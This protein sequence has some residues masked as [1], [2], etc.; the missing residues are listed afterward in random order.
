MDEKAWGLRMV[1]CINDALVPGTGRSVVAILQLLGSDV[2]FPESQTRCSQAMVNPGYLDWAV[3]VERTTPA[4]DRR[5]S[6]S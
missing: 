3:P 4:L 1:T 5:A 2:E 6:V